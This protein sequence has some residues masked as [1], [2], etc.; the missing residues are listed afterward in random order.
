MKENY[1]KQDENVSA[2]PNYKFDI[3]NGSYGSYKNV[4]AGVENIASHNYDYS[5]KLI[6]LIMSMLKNYKL[7]FTLK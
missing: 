1:N 6:I 7:E 5:P 2:D 4:S 3:E